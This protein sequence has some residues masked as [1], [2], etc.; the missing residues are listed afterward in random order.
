M[1]MV[2]VMVFHTKI[3]FWYLKASLEQVEGGVLDAGLCF[4]P[5]KDDRSLTIAL[6]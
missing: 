6:Y 4:D 3:N 5:T 2:M 1:V